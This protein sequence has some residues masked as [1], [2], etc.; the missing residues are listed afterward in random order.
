MFVF[1]ELI[2]HGVAAETTAGVGL[3]KLA[4]DRLWGEIT[5]HLSQGF[6][7]RQRIFIPHLAQD[8]LPPPGIAATETECVLLVVYGLRRV[9][10]NLDQLAV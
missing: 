4:D 8:A 9:F 1:R 6:D 5:A 7:A 10:F 2:A 3:P